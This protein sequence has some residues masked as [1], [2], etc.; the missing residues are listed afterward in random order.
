V[1]AAL[2]CRRECRF[3]HHETTALRTR[4]PL[5]LTLPGAINRW[6]LALLLGVLSAC[7]TTPP[8]VES[9]SDTPW[10]LRRAA[11][12]ALDTWSVV[13]RIS[14]HDGQRGW[15][16]GLRWAQHED[17]FVIDIIGP[18]GQ[19]RVR[20]W[21]DLQSVRLRTADGRVVRAASAEDLL[22]AV[23]GQRLPV[24]AMKYW[25]RGLPNPERRS[26]LA[27]DER[28]RLTQL[29]QDDWKIDYLR[30]LPVA[31]LELPTR[32]RAHRDALKVQ[33]VIERW[34]LEAPM[35]PALL[36]QAEP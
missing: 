21:G 20:I 24:A 17:V 36:V 8:P 2:K 18:F 11:L 6:L 15:Q 22:E 25:V 35:P 5:P 26:V 13:G 12:T 32:I 30:Y 7:A 16:A 1:N 27:G 34:A 9:L 33:L 3:E 23:I 29:E 19:G 28:G 14:V 31:E 10:P 4:L